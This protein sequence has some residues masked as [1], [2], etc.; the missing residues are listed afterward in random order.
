MRTGFPNLHERSPR[1]AHP[2][3]P[4]VHLDPSRQS[5]AVAA[6]RAANVRRNEVLLLVAMGDLG[7]AD[8]L[9]EAASDPAIGRI[10]LQRLLESLPDWTDRRAKQCVA[11]L[12][13]EYRPTNATVAW[14]NGGRSP[15][16][17]ITRLLELVA[18]G[19]RRP[20][21]P[22]WPFEVIV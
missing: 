19:D 8:V 9:A 13:A 6:A 10:R 3:G 11:S 15:E 21:T 20:P 12:T 14:V 7:V 16:V 5:D 1:P 2:G 18:S 22:L 4:G 17:R